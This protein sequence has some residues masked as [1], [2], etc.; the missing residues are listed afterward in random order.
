M[1]VCACDCREWG[2]VGF[3]TFDPDQPKRRK[4]TCLSILSA[5]LLVEPANKKAAAA[6]SV[7]LQR[8][9]LG[10]LQPQGRRNHQA[11]ELL[12]VVIY[13]IPQQALGLC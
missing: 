13:G 10:G 7:A 9:H 8:R 12:E 11:T 5:S 1:C 6:V 2:R 4:G 3:E